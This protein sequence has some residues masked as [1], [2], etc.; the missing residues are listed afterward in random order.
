[1]QWAISCPEQG[2]LQVKKIQVPKPKWGEVL[3]K[4]MAAPINPSDLAFMKGFYD[5]FNLFKVP[6]P[7]VPGWEGS[8]IVVATGG[9]PIAWWD[10]GRRVSFTRKVDVGEDGMEHKNLGGCFQ[11]YC[12]A[13][14]LHV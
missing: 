6:Y 14:A 4:V 2:K 13:N 10:K 8:G 1:M 7:N 9:G 3:I 12:I 5:E 11:Q